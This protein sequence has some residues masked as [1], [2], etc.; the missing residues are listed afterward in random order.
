MPV[1]DIRI[2]RTAVRQRRVAMNMRVRFGAVPR[3]VMDVAMVIV[4]QMGMPSAMRRLKFSRN[5]DQARSAVNTPS[6]LSRSDAL[7]A[8]M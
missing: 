3:K 1:M 6:R 8:E 2:V 5:T 7:E 4:V